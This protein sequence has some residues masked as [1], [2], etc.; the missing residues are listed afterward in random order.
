MSL[1]NSQIQQNT[2]DP[3]DPDPFVIKAESEL[4]LPAYIDQPDYVR[5]KT[6]GYGLHI[7]GWMVWVGLFLPLLTL[8]LWW[9]QGV[10]ILDQL[11]FNIQPR[12][13]IISISHL[14]LMIVILSGVFM[15]W[16]C[17]D[18]IRFIGGKRSQPTSVVS[19]DELSKSFIIPVQTLTDM[20]QQKMQTLHFDDEGHFINA[21]F[22][23][24]PVAMS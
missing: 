24:H 19:V 17:Y 6:A 8:L 4:E 14:V 23:D 16:I 10:T 22:S 18:W 9:F 5:N 13:S 2:L 15:L 20:Q 21:D 12:N 3:V 7:L 1:L 11:I